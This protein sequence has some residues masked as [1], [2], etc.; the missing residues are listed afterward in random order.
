[1]LPFSVYNS[2]L[3]N[4]K[5]TNNSANGNTFN[6]INSTIN[7][8]EFWETYYRAPGGSTTFNFKNCIINVPTEFSSTN[9][10]ALG[11]NSAYDGKGVFDIT[12]D[13][14]EINIDNT[15]FAYLIYIGLWG[16][17]SFTRLNLTIK[18]CVINNNTS[19]TLKLFMDGNNHLTADYCTL[20]LENNT[21]NGAVVQS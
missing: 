6:L 21:Y 19:N 7:V 12:F 16:G 18:N 15:S 10:I 13:G 2:T 4:G 11:S 8:K 14:C 9:F 3:T 5:V 20:V 17:T 1:M